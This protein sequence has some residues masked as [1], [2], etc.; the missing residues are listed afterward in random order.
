MTTNTTTTKSKK[1][2]RT[3]ADQF[4]AKGG[5][6]VPYPMPSLPRLS[7][8]QASNSQLSSGG[9]SPLASAS[10]SAFPTSWIGGGGAAVEE[11]HGQAAALSG[12][13]G[14]QG[15]LGGAGVSGISSGAGGTFGKALKKSAS[16]PAPFRNLAKVGRCRLT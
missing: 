15:S 4:A 6:A 10:T 3:N 7:V 13:P 1:A 16:E 14:S 5:A 9:Q 12:L 8:P 11:H 2:P